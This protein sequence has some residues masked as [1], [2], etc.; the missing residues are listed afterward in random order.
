MS[1]YPTGET[2]SGRG[3]GPGAFLLHDRQKKTAG[4]PKTRIKFVKEVLDMKN[5]KLK[6]LAALALSAVF[7]LCALT[8]C[9]PG[10]SSFAPA[11]AQDASTP[12]SAAGQDSLREVTVGLIQL[13]EHP[14]LDEIRTA[15]E[16]RLEE[17]AAENGLVIHINYQNGQGDASTINTI[18]QQFVGD[19]VDAIVAIATP[20]AQGAATAADGTGIPIIFSAVTDPVAAGLVE[21]LDAPEG[22]ITGTS[23][24]VPV[25]KIFALA[26]ELTPDVQSFGLLYNPGEDNSVSVIADVKAYLD[27]KGI[28]YIESGVSSTGDVQT[29]A[30]SLLSQC[31]AIF[32]PTDNTVA[33]A[34]G[35]LADEAI[36]A[37]KPVYVAA[38]SMVHDGGLATVGVNY[39]NLGAQTADMLLKVLTGTPVSEVPVEVLRDNAVVVNPETAEAIGV[40]VSKYEE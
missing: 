33:S 22:S 12:A 36:K 28:S 21:N 35:V 39:T 3:F 6:K 13:M 37:K 2:H 7:A 16:A 10:N 4:P 8:A 5:M 17:K 1:V 23:D 11:P 30:Q 29:A 40:D 14:S 20:A 19:K 25:D 27:G 18:C 32:S 9:A 34:M 24:A 15:I 31:D 26:A 38:D